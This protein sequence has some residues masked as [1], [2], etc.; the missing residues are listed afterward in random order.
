MEKV[1]LTDF[2]TKARTQLI[3]ERN[4]LAVHWI[5]GS[6]ELSTSLTCLRMAR[7]PNPLFCVRC[8]QKTLATRE[9]ELW[10]CSCNNLVNHAHMKKSDHLMRLAQECQDTDQVFLAG[11]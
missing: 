7:F 9:H 5:F 6:V 8:D 3:K 1:I 2:A 10:E 11:C 4:F